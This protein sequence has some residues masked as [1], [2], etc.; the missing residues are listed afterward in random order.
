[1]K[2]VKIL[3]MVVALI[4]S[5]MNLSAQTQ[6]VMSNDGK[7]NLRSTPSK[8]GAKAGTLAAGEL[9]PCLEELDG[10]YKVA[11]NGKEAYVS[12]TVTSTCDAVIPSSIFKKDLE[13]SQPMD[14]IRFSGT[15]RITPVD[16]THVLIYTEWMRENLPA[17]SQSYLGKIKDGTITATHQ[18]GTYVDEEASLSA[19]LDE[20]TKLDNPIPMGFD[21]FGN[22]IYFDGGL[23]S[24]FE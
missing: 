14:K 6:Y 2:K 11:Y 18:V 16:Q 1:M 15:I 9:L 24:E 5:A 13:S 19:I 3:F 23:Y 17:E 12:Q 8:T 4:A 7:V 22:T 21:E 20:M 10:W